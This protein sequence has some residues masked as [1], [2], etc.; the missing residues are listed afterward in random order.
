MIVQS[1]DHVNIR[2]KDPDATICFFKDVLGMGVAAAPSGQG[3]WL[4]DEAGNAVVHVGNAVAPYPSDAWRAFDASAKGGAVHHVAFSCKGYDE[5][6]QRLDDSG[7]DY[8]KGGV[9]RLGLRQI[10]VAE[11]GGVLLELNFRDS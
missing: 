3:G 1:L 5:V 2:V 4:V 6:K 8:L 10:F 7:L 11:P 9:P